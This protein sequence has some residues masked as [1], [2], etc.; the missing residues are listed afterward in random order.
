ML[1]RRLGRL[2]GLVAVLAAFA[3]GASPASAV[4]Q[5]DTK[6]GVVVSEWGYDEEVSYTTLDFEWG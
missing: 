4:A 5:P 6:A 3:G 2:A 1:A